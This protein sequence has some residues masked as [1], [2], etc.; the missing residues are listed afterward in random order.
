MGGAQ[1]GNPSPR[2]DLWSQVRACSGL[3]LGTAC[4]L[5]WWSSSWVILN[6]G[7]LRLVNLSCPPV[8]SSLTQGKD[9]CKLVA[10]DINLGNQ[11]QPLPERQYSTYPPPCSQEPSLLC[12]E[13]SGM[14]QIKC[15]IFQAAF[16]LSPVN[17]P[18]PI[19]E[20]SN[21]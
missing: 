9:P 11:S 3:A 18:L 5:R 17:S 13:P 4:L 1:W 2:D 19:S 20:G 12:G 6:L 14:S 15:H 16:L 7:N 8:C 10:T 21:A